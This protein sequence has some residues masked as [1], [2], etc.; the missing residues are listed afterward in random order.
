METQKIS[1][2]RVSYLHSRGIDPVVS[3]IDLEMVKLKLRE[4]DEDKV[5]T[6]DEC[7]EAKTEYKRFL[8]LVK[9]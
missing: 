1:R 3:V 2:K 8:H 6:A 7:E 5:W 9:K 4:P